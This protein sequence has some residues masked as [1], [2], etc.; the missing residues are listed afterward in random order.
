MITA[1]LKDTVKLLAG[2]HLEFTYKDVSSWSL[3]AAGAMALLYSV[4]D[5]NIIPS[6]HVPHTFS[7]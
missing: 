1:H 7:Y 2:T 4:V 3:R 6:R 5:N